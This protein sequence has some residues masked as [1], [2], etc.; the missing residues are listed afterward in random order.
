M[1]CEAMMSTEISHDDN[2]PT[3]IACVIQ[4]K[5]LLLQNKSK[6]SEDDQSNNHF[7]L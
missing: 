2:N 7:K 4:E 5:N 6:L 3:V 1:W